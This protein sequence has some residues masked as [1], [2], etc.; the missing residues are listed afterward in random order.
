MIV[1][2]GLGNIGLAIA[3]RI[4]QCGRTVCGVDLSPERR[5]E[6]RETTGG[7]AAADLASVT[8]EDAEMV[9]V[10]VRLTSQAEQVLSQLAALPIRTGTPVLVMTTLEL[11][12]ARSVGGY[13]DRG[14]RV[15]ECPVS[16]GER[17]AAQGQLTVMVAGELYE[18]EERLLLD[19]VAAHVVRFAAY[20]EPTT[21][22]LLNNVAAAYN[23]RALAEILLLG[24][25]LG[26]DPR[27]LHEVIVSSSGGSWM[28]QAFLVLVDDLLDKD[29]AL[30]REQ[31]GELPAV[32][33][34][35]DADLV[36]RLA[37]ARA[38]LASGTGAP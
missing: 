19:T 20:G 36:G 26:L 28:A 3:V 23:A 14:L 13:A 34:G 9:V 31:L 6:W 24:K 21:A 2:I 7:E 27:R 22:K 12:F 29:V 38:L 33:L 37:Q 17:G 30:L 5:R 32:S 4:A 8:W 18:A 16:G 25:T 35:P 1:V 10:L 11:G 15:V